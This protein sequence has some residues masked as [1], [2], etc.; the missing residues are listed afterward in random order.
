MKFLTH[1]CPPAPW[2]GWGSARKEVQIKF[3]TTQSVLGA[4][5]GAG[6]RQ[7][8]A[9]FEHPELCTLTRMTRDYIRKGWCLTGI[10]LPALLAAGDVTLQEQTVLGLWSLPAPL[11]GVC[12]S[13]K[14]PS[15][16]SRAL[17]MS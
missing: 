13:H 3:P 11:R 1:E 7:S 10:H 6:P 14:T 17:G 2:D 15:E 12:K 9:V 16:P 8:Q 5:V 4:L